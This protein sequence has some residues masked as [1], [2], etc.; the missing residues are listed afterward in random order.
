MNKLIEKL[1]EMAKPFVSRKLV[2]LGVSGTAVDDV[3][4]G[5]KDLGVSPNTALVCFVVLAGI[6]LVVQGIIDYKKEGIKGVIA[7]I[8]AEVKPQ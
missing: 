8:K 6:Y 1:G 4:A 3:V 7:G 2:A 5:L